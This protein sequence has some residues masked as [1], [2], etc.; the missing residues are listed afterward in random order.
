MLAVLLGVRAAE[1]GVVSVGGR[2]P[3]RHAAASR[4]RI[5]YVGPE[6]Y[7]FAGTIRENL[8]YGSAAAIEESAL[9]AALDR[10]AARTLVD[11]LDGGLDHV[12]GEDGAPLSS[13]ERQ[14]LALA[15]ALAV[16]PTLLVLDEPTAHV[17]PD[18]ERAIL[19]AVAALR[20]TVT[21]VMAL[22]REELATGC[23]LVVRT[24]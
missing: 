22:H 5:G 20:G 12:L 8:A 9:R 23:D 18:A 4:G 24:R 3:A 13:G 1:S 2:S 16:S 7:L 15:R 14:R 10:A 19:G 11:G 17:D 21:C 6:P